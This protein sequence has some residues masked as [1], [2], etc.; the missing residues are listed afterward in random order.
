M[1]VRVSLTATQI[2]AVSNF[3][4]TNGE[5][6]RTAVRLP[7][8]R[9]GRAGEG[10][11]RADSPRPTEPRS[12]LFDCAMK[13]RRSKRNRRPASEGVTGNSTHDP[14]MGSGLGST[15]PK[16]AYWGLDSIR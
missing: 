1:I 15:A 6:E 13:G 12:K 14:V 7:T 4:A 2:E 11:K 10:R 9:S 8:L 5:H 3:L 16:T